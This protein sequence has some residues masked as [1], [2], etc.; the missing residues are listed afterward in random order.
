MRILLLSLGLLLAWPAASAQELHPSL[1]PFAMMIGQ[2]EG[3]AEARMPQG[4]MVMQQTED[5]RVELGGNLIV[6]EGMGR[7]LD[8]DGEPGEVVF[9]AYGILSVDAQTGTAYLDAFTMEGRHTRV[10]PVVTEDGFEWSITPEQGP[11]IH[12]VMRLDEEGRWVETGQV[13]LDGGTTWMPFFEMTLE[14]VSE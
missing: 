7:Q 3:R 13:S 4:A 9:N 6:I 2:W 11:R 12:Y 8:A 14:R 1:E 10:A 5:V